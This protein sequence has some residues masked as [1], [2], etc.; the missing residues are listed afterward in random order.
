[1]YHPMD[2]TDEPQ[3]VR[4]ALA[5]GDRELAAA[6]AAITEARARHNPEVGSVAGSAAHARGLLDDDLERLALA[7]TLYESGPRPLALASA[8]E[9]FG[10]LALRQESR[11]VGLDALGRA[12]VV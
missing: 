12:L 1:V 4:I 7:V 3:L 5:C 11:Q 10:R 2:V 9:D 6:A 8:L